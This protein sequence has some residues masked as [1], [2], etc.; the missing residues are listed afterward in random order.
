M[1]KEF[2][3]V[4]VTIDDSYDTNPLITALLQRKLAACIQVMPIQSHYV[5]QEKVC[6]DKEKLLIIKTR[7]DCYQT[8]ESAIV[9]IHPYDVPQ[10][11]CIDIE[12]GFDP[13]LAWVR[14][15]TCRTV[16]K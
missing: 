6:S 1:T 4:L 14:E 3:I 7:Y 12:D 15:N 2:C 16:K 10:I 9:E 8:L 5:W 11:V 13:Y